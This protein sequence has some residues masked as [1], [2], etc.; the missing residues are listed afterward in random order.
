MRIATL[1]GMGF[2]TSMMLKLFIDD[3]LKA[4]G[5]KA[6]VVPWDLGTFKGQKADIVVAPKDMESHL[7]SATAKVVLINNLVDKAEIKT[8]V[9]EVI[10]T[11]PKTG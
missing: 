5:L 11:L 8:K 7:R 1:C 10:N 6:E 2:G 9:L 4:E 3:I